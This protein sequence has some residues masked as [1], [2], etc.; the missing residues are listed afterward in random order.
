MYLSWYPIANVII[1]NILLCDVDVVVISANPSLFSASGISGIICRIPG[2]EWDKEAKPL[3]SLK[4]REAVITPSFKP[5]AQY[6]VHS[7]CPRYLDGMRGEDDQLAAGYASALG[8]Y[9]QLRNPYSIASILKPLVN[10]VVYN[11]F[12]AL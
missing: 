9:D 10:M 11:Q 2:P 12:K 6:A 5:H 7:V 4:P 3:G 8:V 1:S